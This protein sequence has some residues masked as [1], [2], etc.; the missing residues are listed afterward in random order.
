MAQAHVRGLQGDR[1]GSPDRLLACAKHFAGYGAAEGGRDYDA[2]NVSDA[3]MWNIYFPPFKA[4][5]DAGVGCVMS[6]YMDLNDIPATGN[7]WLLRDVLRRDWKFSGFVVSDANS[8]EEMKNHGF[9]R[10]AMDAAIKG[11]EF[12][13]ECLSEEPWRRD[14]TEPGFSKRH[15]RPRAPIIGSQD[16]ARLV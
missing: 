8:V 13:R 11:N 10:D 14:Q 2:S 4:A 15:R 6:A 16:Q 3:Q 9:A 1:I 5:V 12:W 7:R